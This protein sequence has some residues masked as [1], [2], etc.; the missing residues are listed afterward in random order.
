MELLHLLRMNNKPKFHKGQ[1]LI[2]I[3]VAVGIIAVVLV[4][5]SDL[6]TRSLNM[7]SFQAKSNKAQNIVKNQLSYYRQQRDLTP[8]DFFDNYE[9]YRTCVG[10]ID[11]GYSCLIEYSPVSS[12]LQMTV[13]VTWSDGDKTINTELSQFLGRPTR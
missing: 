11:A 8:T 2:E 1:S 4:G 5:V 6:V 13:T 12:N 3:V 9:N 10:V 7:A